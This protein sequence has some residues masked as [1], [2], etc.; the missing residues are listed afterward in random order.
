MGGRGKLPRVLRR[1]LG[2][3]KAEAKTI[4]KQ[5]LIN[6][7]GKAKGIQEGALGD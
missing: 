1:F 6:S 2:G 7:N 4:I 3:S 5:I